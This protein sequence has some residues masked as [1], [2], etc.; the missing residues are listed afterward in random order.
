MSKQKRLKYPAT[1]RFVDPDLLYV[2]VRKP[3]AK[4]E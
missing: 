3:K 2:T 1:A 4:K